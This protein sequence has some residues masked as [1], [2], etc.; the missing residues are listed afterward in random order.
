M[1]DMALGRS[2][3]SSRRAAGVESAK[4]IDVKTARDEELKKTGDLFACF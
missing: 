2:G 1:T 3:I 4:N